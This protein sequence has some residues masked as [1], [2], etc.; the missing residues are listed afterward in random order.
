ME[1]SAIANAGGPTAADRLTEM[2][3]RIEAS[4]QDGRLQPAS[5]EPASSRDSKKIE[6]PASAASFESVLNEVWNGNKSPLQSLPEGPAAMKIFQGMR[7]VGAMSGHFT[8][9]LVERI[10]QPVQMPD[11]DKYNTPEPSG[12]SPEEREEWMVQ[13]IRNSALAHAELNQWATQ[14]HMENA[15]LFMVGSVAAAKSKMVSSIAKACVTSFKDVL[16]S[17]R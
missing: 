10:N 17:S 7:D 2:M 14:Q 9:L 16:N 3:S 15:A 8:K 13:N 1:I 11:M 6:P 5:A 4:Q 12:D